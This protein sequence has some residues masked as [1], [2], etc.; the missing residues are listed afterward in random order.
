M[1]TSSQP[2][3]RW[4][5]LVERGTWAHSDRFVARAFVRPFLRFAQVEASSGLVLVAAAAAALVWAN[6][7]FDSYQTFF[8][9]P[10]LLEFGP[11]HIEEDLQHVINDGLMALF[12]F[13][14]GLEIKRELVA[15]EL[16]D[17][18][19]AMLPALG[20]LGGM[21]V[22]ALIYLV[23]VGAGG[24]AGRGWGIP[25]AT[26]IAF[27]V[28][29]ISLLG[30]RAPDGAKL[31]LLTL[32]IADDIGAI[33]VIAIFYTDDL[34]VVWLG[35]AGV[36]L[37]AVWG[38]SRIG[39]RSM[40]FY[41]PAALVVWFATFESGVHA[42][43]AGVA[44]GL[45]TPA[46]PYYPLNVV[47]KAGRNFITRLESE[48]DDVIERERADYQLLALSEVARESVAPLARIEHRLGLWASYFVIPL[49]ALANAGV[50]FGNTPIGQSLLTPVGLGVALGLVVGKLVGITLFTMASVRI[51]W[52]RLPSGMD[53]R[54]L[55]G[56]SVLA[57]IGFTVSL[58][59]VNLAFSDAALI[60]DAKVG[61]LAASIVAG[62]GGYLILRSSRPSQ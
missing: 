5:E 6:V 30:R 44:L 61:I 28:G 33:G 31:F 25:M 19:K 53:T 32:A 42:T 51:G 47:H 3:A 60:A 17:P 2:V 15:G 4:A 49:F 11:L 36:G 26:D 18:R 24:E 23:V 27:A 50:H 48:D 8:G 43:L 16:S 34:N 46:R 35:I 62:I 14:V 58:F 41:V 9:A 10:F 37:L 7:A 20:A 57:G 45:L 38:A 54:H 21:V 1:R 52:G 40:S 59:I 29:V 22:P 39:I 56:V 12:F 13:V 55:I